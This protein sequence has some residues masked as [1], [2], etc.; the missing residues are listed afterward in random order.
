MNHHLSPV[1]KPAPPRP[2]GPQI[3]DLDDDGVAA[4]LE[5][6]LG[7]IPGA[8]C[9]GAGQTPVAATIEVAKGDPC[10]MGPQ[11]GPTST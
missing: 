10:S 6:R 8:A 11:R 9:A 5:D 1:G 7:A 3:L 4:F 2:R